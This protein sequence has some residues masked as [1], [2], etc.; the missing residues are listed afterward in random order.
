MHWNTVTP[1]L[2]DVLIHMMRSEIF[3]VFRLVGGTSL[4]L[5]IGHRESVDIDLFTDAQYDSLDFGCIDDYFRKHY[6]YVST[7][8]GLLISLGKSWYV[9]TDQSNAVKIDVYY[10][11]PF[12]RPLLKKEN[13]RLCS[14]EDVIAMKLEVLGRG[15]R[16]KD[17]WDLH[18]LHEH[19]SIQ[20]MIDL[21]QERYPYSHSVEEL[22]LSFVNFENAED[23]LEPICLLGKHWPLIKLDF[24]QWIE[25]AREIK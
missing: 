9:G 11:D 14:V 7:N 15:G 3:E 20:K 5:Q 12:I 25:N 22:H 24:V 16:K 13:I 6:S 23:D 8:D 19:Y 4:S 17:F 21:H 1:L 18:A 10:T 2:K